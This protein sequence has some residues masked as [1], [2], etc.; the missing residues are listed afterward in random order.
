MANGIVNPGTNR[1]AEWI[2]VANDNRARAEEVRPLGN[3]LAAKIA[4]DCEQFARVAD[5]TARHY[6]AYDAG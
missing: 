3:A 2:K 5:D 4:A 1:R 6:E